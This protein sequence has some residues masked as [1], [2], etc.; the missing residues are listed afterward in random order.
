[1]SQLKM[2]E[3]TKAQV[4]ALAIWQVEATN[5]PNWCER[6]RAGVVKIH[7]EE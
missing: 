6:G 7:W 3:L 4:F 2:S 5:I 1:M